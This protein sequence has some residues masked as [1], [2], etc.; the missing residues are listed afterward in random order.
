MDIIV[1]IL[2]YVLMG[3]AMLLSI[4]LIIG[5]KDYK[6]Y[7]FLW[8]CVAIIAIPLW[9]YFSWPIPYALFGSTFVVQMFNKFK[10]IEGTNSAKHD[11]E[12]KAQA[13]QYAK[14]HPLT[15]NGHTAEMAE[16]A[17]WVKHFGH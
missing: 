4:A 16:M 10:P 6:P 13:E 8:A 15:F 7:P 11:A 3:L 12:M 5:F 17:S 14:E 2:N 1:T 9:Y